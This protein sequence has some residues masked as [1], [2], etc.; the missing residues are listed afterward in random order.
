ML[1]VLQSHIISASGAATGP[2]VAA[3]VGKRAT[4]QAELVHYLESHKGSV[5]RVMNSGDSSDPGAAELQYQQQ[6]QQGGDG[7]FMYGSSTSN[8]SNG[9]YSNG[10]SICGSIRAHSDRC[11]NSSSNGTSY[12]ISS[13]VSPDHMV[14]PEVASPA[15]ARRASLSAYLHGK[16]D[17]VT[18]V[19]TGVPYADGSSLS[20]TYRQSL[21]SQEI[22]PEA[23]SR[24][25]PSSCYCE[26]QVQQQGTAKAAAAAAANDRHT[27]VKEALS[28][29]L[30][31]AGRIS[32]QRFDAEVL[33][34]VAIT[35]G[36]LH[37]VQ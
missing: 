28:A 1:L 35:R 6:Q 16:Q 34:C 20:S 18:T 14:S 10:V 29:R 23:S 5:C 26:P 25:R 36:T 2:A 12:T 15:S 22:S 37:S 9:A 33:S 4:Q 24:Y 3:F 19:T 31:N 27:A 7:A 8:S 32:K 11:L 30:S 21:A 17:L 13:Q